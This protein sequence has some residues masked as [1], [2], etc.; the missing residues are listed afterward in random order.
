MN[1][2]WMLAKKI[3]FNKNSNELDV[4]LLEETILSGATMAFY[5]YKVDGI[6]KT[7]LSDPTQNKYTL[8]LSRLDMADAVLYTIAFLKCYR[9]SSI[10]RDF[11]KTAKK[12][13]DLGE[14]LSAKFMDEIGFERPLFQEWTKLPYNKQGLEYDYGIENNIKAE[15]ELLEVF[16]A[17]H[18]KLMTN[19]G[20]DFCE[21]NGIGIQTLLE[22]TNPRFGLKN[23]INTTAKNAKSST[24]RS[25]NNNQEE[26]TTE[27][28]SLLE[29]VFLTKSYNS[30]YDYAKMGHDSTQKAFLRKKEELKL[31]HTIEKFFGTRFSEVAVLFTKDARKKFSSPF[32]LLGKYFTYC[33]SSSIS[34]KKIETFFRNSKYKETWEECLTKV[35]SYNNS[36]RIGEL[37][38]CFSALALPT[39]IKNASHT[40]KVFGVTQ[41]IFNLVEPYVLDGKFLKSDKIA[42]LF[43]THSPV[44]PNTKFGIGAE[45]C[46]GLIFLDLDLK[47]TQSLVPVIE[48]V[49]Q[50]LKVKQQF[51]SRVLKYLHE[52]LSNTYCEPY[53]MSKLSVSG[54]GVHVIFK[55]LQPP[56]M[57]R[58]GGNGVL[59]RYTEKDSES[60]L[61]LQE[62]G[63]AH[64][65]TLVMEVLK[66]VELHDFF[67]ETLTIDDGSI[68]GLVKKGGG[69]TILDGSMRKIEQGIAL[70]H[71]DET[72][73]NMHHKQYFVLSAIPMCYITNIK[74]SN[75]AVV[76]KRLGE[77]LKPLSKNFDNYRYILSGSSDLRYLV[78]TTDSFNIKL[79]S[80]E[81]REMRKLDKK[82]IA[83]VNRNRGAYDN[84]LFD[85]VAF[86]LFE[87]DISLIRPIQYD[88]WDAWKA[89]DFKYHIKRM[90]VGSLLKG[91]IN[92]QFGISCE[93]H[94]SSDDLEKLSSYGKPKEVYKN[95]RSKYLDIMKVL[96]SVKV[97]KSHHDSHEWEEHLFDDG[98]C[99]WRNTYLT[100][101]SIHR[102][103]GIE[104]FKSS[105]LYIRRMEQ[106]LTKEGLPNFKQQYYKQMESTDPKVGKVAKLVASVLSLQ[107]DKVVT[108][109]DFKFL[110]YKNA[111]QLLIDK[112]P[113]NMDIEIVPEDIGG[114]FYMSDY[115]PLL[116]KFLDTR[117]FNYINARAGAGKTTYFTELA[118]KHSKRVLL[119]MPYTAPMDSKFGMEA[120]NREIDIIMNNKNL[121]PSEKEDWVAA[122]QAFKPFSGSKN[123]KEMMEAFKVGTSSVVTFDKF[124]RMD[125][126]LLLNYDYVAIDEIHILATETIRS[127][128]ADSVCT[129]ALKRIR[130]VLQYKEENPY[131]RVPFIIGMTGTHIYEV[132]L[133]RMCEKDVK[134]GG[135]KIEVRNIKL[136]IPHQSQK[137][138]NIILTNSSKDCKTLLCKKIATAMI[139]NRTVICP[140]DEGSFRA[141]EIVM[142]I[143]AHLEHMDSDPLTKDDWHYYKRATKDSVTSKAINGQSVIPNDIK[144]LF[145]SVYLSV[146]VD[147]KNLSEDKDI[148]VI[149]TFA[150]YSAQTLEQF[151]NRLRKQNINTS[152]IRSV[153]NETE[154]NKKK[155][156]ELKRDYNNNL[157][158]RFLK[159]IHKV[160]DGEMRARISD[161]KCVAYFNHYISLNDEKIT[162]QQKIAIWA[163]LSKRFTY[164]YEDYMGEI[165]VV[166]DN[167]MVLR[168]IAEQQYNRLGTNIRYIANMFKKHYNYNSVNT[169]YIDIDEPHIV[170]AIEQ[171]RSE[172]S[173]ERKKFSVDVAKEIHEFLKTTKPKDIESFISSC[174]TEMVPSNNNKITI[175]QGD[176]ATL[177]IEYPEKH[178][179]RLKNITSKL[180][181][182][183]KQYAYNPKNFSI[184]V[185]MCMN[186]KSDGLVIAELE[187][188]SNLIDFRNYDILDNYI[189]VVQQLERLALAKRGKRMSSH[190]E[191]LESA[192]N[193]I[194]KKMIKDITLHLSNNTKPNTQSTIGIAEDTKKKMFEAYESLTK[195]NYVI[196]EDTYAKLK[197]SVYKLATMVLMN[198]DVKGIST[199]SDYNRSRLENRVEENLKTF[200]IIK[201]NPH[202]KERDVRLRILPSDY[203]HIMDN[204]VKT[205]GNDNMKFYEFEKYLI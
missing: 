26:G 174:K 135:K 91:L 175:N 179:K 183:A 145:C 202:T 1:S 33:N 187:R 120:Q 20:R 14:R 35:S 144:V 199:I 18:K 53:L 193:K 148:E 185:D 124:S 164:T 136:E 103:V 10:D 64:A 67:G 197:M 173:E 63:Y 50:S 198:N 177:L 104:M 36:Y 102:K 127:A 98:E 117:C 106:T 95:I 165:K 192:E 167:L 48:R 79:N 158:Y 76:K 74:I 81:I 141:E 31:P 7:E 169:T 17:L 40:K 89:E 122:I 65:F 44:R 180:L 188:F 112:N 43:Q 196:S 45:M 100:K 162:E 143:N 15:N 94:P 113:M 200:F 68:G 11:Y 130:E 6:C 69:D 119:V 49:G 138:M 160:I 178:H 88:D 60:S 22:I 97:K 137:N 153:Y 139:E 59:P 78:E 46:N 32:P 149:S 131:E 111:C 29:L 71:S 101:S 2:F 132:N 184:L 93:Q 105:G 28:L 152:L 80:S 56:P 92:S 24:S 57:N 142:G 66:D 181:P 204:I 77:N 23:L 21:E 108:D 186:E 90:K 72:F 182:I 39:S 27:F 161:D 191:T 12:R 109:S 194:R 129:M 123:N 41:E 99:P 85:D 38:E 190:I 86:D 42:F 107:N 30:K 126:E 8:R 125:V 110:N 151:G 133:F 171:S 163:D 73:V 4:S 114:G 75:L 115:A 13:G 96:C 116:E 146:G 84:K 62:L 205:Y 16:G 156:Y 157:D 61:L 19:E 195:I 147:I 9:Y 134:H 150:K 168:Y 201:T 47:F 166:Q 34:T 52:R 189:M 159:G 128:D 37:I 118:T 176:G 170:G 54:T 121:H 154:K 87:V 83:R 55:Y 51:A 70:I 58:E 140:T 3:F 5:N 172:N 82:V 203:R 155:Y 25:L